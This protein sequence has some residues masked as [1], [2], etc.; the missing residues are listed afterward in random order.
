VVAP[1]SHISGISP[2]LT[3]SQLATLYRSHEILS[4]LARQAQLPGLWGILESSMYCLTYRDLVLRR[5]FLSLSRHARILS[6]LDPTDSSGTLPRELLRLLI[7]HCDYDP[8][9]EFAEHSVLSFGGYDGV[10]SQL[11]ASQSLDFFLASLRPLGNLSIRSRLRCA[12]TLNDDAACSHFLRLC[13]VD[14]TNPELAQA[15]LGIIS[16]TIESE[17][18]EWALSRAPWFSSLRTSPR[19]YNNY[20]PLPATA[21]HFAV[22]AMWK[23]WGK[24]P[25][26]DEWAMLVRNL[27]ANGAK[28]IYDGPYSSRP[29]PQFIECRYP[30]P[31]MVFLCQDFDAKSTLPAALDKLRFW[32]SL[33]RDAGID[34]VEYGAQDSRYCRTI[35]KNHGESL[36]EL[37]RGL[38]V[39]DFVY[40]ADPCEWSLV[41]VPLL[42]IPLFERK[43]EQIPGA[44]EAASHHHDSWQDLLFYPTATE[45]GKWKNGCETARSWATSLIKWR[46]SSS[47]LGVLKQSGGPHRIEE[48]IKAITRSAMEEVVAETQDDAGMVTLLICRRR[49]NR[50]TIRRSTSQPPSM[51]RRG[52]EY[53]R[54]GNVV[55]HEWL[56]DYHLCPADGRYRVCPSG[57]RDEFVRSWY[58]GFCGGDFYMGAECLQTWY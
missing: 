45:R 7:D 27:T 56:G 46:L 26:I 3:R 16:R 15:G 49:S 2:L 41:V 24:R 29:G 54:P 1:E 30:T 38:V 58:Q 55:H 34:L 14:G 32:A 17:D 6:A 28:H 4:F 33:M 25:F 57:M 21:L 12:L 40:S 5:S 44:W 50:A 9:V 20:N 52:D 13:G 53:R 23:S 51:S 47:Y 11:V 43:T 10:M 48:D 18:T 39:H 22:R 35:W 31:L 19:R 36:L 8:E 37:D 42:R